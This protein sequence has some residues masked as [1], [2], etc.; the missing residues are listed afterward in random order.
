MNHKGQIQDMLSIMQQCY[1]E[2]DEKNINKIY[3]AFFDEGIESQ[4]IGTDNGEWF[5]TVEEIKELLVEF[6]ENK[7]PNRKIKIYGDN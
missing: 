4:L 2:R 3:D 6:E 1:I 5:R 7:N